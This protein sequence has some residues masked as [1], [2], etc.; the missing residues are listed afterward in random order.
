MQSSFQ[1]TTAPPLPATDEPEV[2]PLARVMQELGR[3]PIFE[4]WG[5]SRY[6]RKFARPYGND[7]SYFGRY[8]DFEAAAAAARSFASH[9]LPDSYDVQA[10]GRAYR[11]QLS[12]IRV[13]DYPLLYWLSRLIDGGARRIFDL[14]G[15]IGVTYYGFG[16][17]LGYPADLRWQVHDMPTVM[18]AGRKWADSHDPAGRISFADSPG[19]ATGCDVLLSTGA[20]QYLEY[21]LPEL[22]QGLSERPAHVLVNLT[23]IH[24][25]LGYFTLQNMGF[26]V[27][28]YR[29]MVRGELVSGMERLGYRLVDEW[30]S[31]ERHLDIPF[32]P[33]CRIDN[34]SGFH[35]TR[36]AQAGA[37]SPQAA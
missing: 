10:A 35:F 11:N 25:Q 33:A 19:H 21:T 30:Q 7:N 37:G 1:T 27:C 14:G 6:R 17:Y 4:R 28:P 29:V 31:K 32:E 26:A 15:N 12:S 24:P 3:L 18:A 8:A 20:L 16:H 9:A 22:L 2:H 36:D 13:S 5:K 23:P 34:Y